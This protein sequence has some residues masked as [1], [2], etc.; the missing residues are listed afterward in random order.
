MKKKLFFAAVAIVALASC[1]DNEF[2]GDNSPTTQQENAADEIQFGLNVQ[3][4]TRA[5]ASIGA[6]AAEKLGGMFVGNGMK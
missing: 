1:S 5:G 4:T 3:N 6:T 2:I